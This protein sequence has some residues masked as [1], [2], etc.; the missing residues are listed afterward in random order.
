M[1]GRGPGT[2]KHRHRTGILWSA[3][4]FR[5]EDRS[6]VCCGV[7]LAEGRNV[8][9]TLTAPP[10]PRVPLKGILVVVGKFRGHHTRL[11]FELWGEAA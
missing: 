8:L 6:P 5:R 2:Y 9:S 11:A 1:V 4:S 3:F 7:E 10:F